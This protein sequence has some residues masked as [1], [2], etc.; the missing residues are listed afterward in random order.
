[1][2]PKRESRLPSS[3]AEKLKRAGQKSGDQEGEGSLDLFK[4]DFGGASSA[5]E[6]PMAKPSATQTPPLAERPKADTS[7]LDAD[8]S[9]EQG[10][11]AEPT[12]V[13]SSP[14]MQRRFRISE[15][16]Y[17]IRRMEVELDFHHEQGRLIEETIREEQQH[18][19]RLQSRTRHSRIVEEE[20]NE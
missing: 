14:S 11:A 18:L 4:R 3:L 7:N 12:P 15:I 13:D 1:M 6:R 16:E 19:D 2:P 5:Q 8:Q 20:S 9:E 17:K 10:G